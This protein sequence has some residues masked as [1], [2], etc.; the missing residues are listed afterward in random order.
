MS[1]DDDIY[2]GLGEILLAIAPAHA[3]AVYLDAQ[4]STQGDHAKMAY[5][6]ATE[7]GDTQW[8]MPESA[9]VD[10]E[11]LLLLV[12]LR[13]FFEQYNLFETGEPWKRCLIKLDLETARI[14]ADFK[15]E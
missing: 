12:K 9:R 13:A 6:Y 8:F 5:D 11:L 7:R 10:A 3:T 4:L 2:Q 1:T 15:Y 14:C